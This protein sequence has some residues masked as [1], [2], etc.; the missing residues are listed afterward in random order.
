MCL[1]QPLF[2]AIYS[3]NTILKIKSAKIMCFLRFLEPE[4]EQNL[5]IFLPDF[6]KWFK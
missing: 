2:L 5:I 3:Q 1:Y 6:I 4:F